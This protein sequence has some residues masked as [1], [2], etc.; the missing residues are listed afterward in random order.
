MGENYR[1]KKLLFFIFIG[2]ATTSSAQFSDTLNFEDSTSVII[3]DSI[4][5]C[6][7]VG[8]PSKIL[9]DSA[10]SAPNAAVTDTLNFYGNNCYESAVYITLPINTAPFAWQLTFYHKYDFE[11]GVDGGSVEFYNCWTSQWEQLSS[12]IWM[13][14]DCNGLVYPTQT[15]LDNNMQPIINGKNGFTGTSNGWQRDSVYFQCV[16]VMQNN[17]TLRGGSGI[18]VHLRFIVYSDANNSNQEGW[19]IDEIIFQ[20]L[21]G[22]CPGSVDESILYD[23][24]DVFPNPAEAQITFETL[25]KEKIY[26]ISVL[27]FSGKK[28]LCE[29]VNEKN[30]TTLD[31]SDF[32]SG[33]YFYFIR[34]SGRNY[35]SGKFVVE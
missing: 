28:V 13:P 16:G 33:M 7:Q 30:K 20:D 22:N 6:W 10:Y 34:S 21:G 35:F 19:M 14:V 11:P 3:V 31:I 27:D 9:F 29:S 25:G 26:E 1:M 8:T 5:G 17:D 24:I 4:T 32:S 23:K 2:V 12:A 18:E 15:S